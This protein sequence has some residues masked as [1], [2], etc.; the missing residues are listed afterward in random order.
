M[1]IIKGMK[2]TVKD[3]EFV[4]CIILQIK[5]KTTI[6]CLGKITFNNLSNTILIEQLSCLYYSNVSTLFE[7][8]IHKRDK[9]SS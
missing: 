2:L 1:N 3:D 4:W 6:K 8:V 9:E 7:L 5:N